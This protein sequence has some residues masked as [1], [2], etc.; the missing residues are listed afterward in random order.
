V[1]LKPFVQFTGPVAVVFPNSVVRYF[2][3][4]RHAL[5]GLGMQPAKKI[6]RLRIIHERLELCCCILHPSPAIQQLSPLDWNTQTVPVEKML[7]VPFT[8]EWNPAL[9]KGNHSA[10]LPRLQ[11]IRGVYE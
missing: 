9:A 1:Y 6:S 3:T 11:V 7:H 4:S 8:C 5:H 2:P 10:A